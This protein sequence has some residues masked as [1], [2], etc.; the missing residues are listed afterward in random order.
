MDSSDLTDTVDMVW[1]DDDDHGDAGVDTDGAAD[2]STAVGDEAVDLVV[3]EFMVF[4]VPEA[5][6]PGSRRTPLES[7]RKWTLP[8]VISIPPRRPKK[9]ERDSIGVWSELEG[10]G[11]NRVPR[12][13]R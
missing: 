2:R 5:I 1:R 13:R 8:N 4:A 9:A 11:T 10:P 7:M 3:Y 12:V 6:G